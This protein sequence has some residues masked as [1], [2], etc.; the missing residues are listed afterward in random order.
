M[1]RPPWLDG[2]LL[3]LASITLCAALI[4]GTARLWVDRQARQ[5]ERSAGSPIS[6]YDPTLGWFHVAGAERRIR[7]PEFDVLL[8]FNRHGLRGPDRDYT[9]PPGVRRA[10]VLGDSF[11]EGYYVDEDQTAAAVLEGLLQACGPHEV[12][13]AGVQGYSTDQEYLLYLQEGRRYGARLVL[14]FFYGNDLRYNASPVGSGGEAKPYFDLDEHD[15]L[16]ARGTPVPPPDPATTSRAR[17]GASRPLP[18]HGSMALRLLSRR[19]VGSNPAL[20]AA[21]ARLGLVEPVSPD[22]PIELWPYGPMHPREVG[23]MWRHTRAILRAL[24]EAVAADGATLALVYVPVRFE[25]NDP[26]WELTRARYQMGRRWGTERVF[27]RLQETC[28]ELDIPLVDPRAPLR[29]AE[30][31]GA[32]AYYT[33]DVHWNARGNAIAAHAVEPL[34]R[35]VLGCAAAATDGARR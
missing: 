9:P 16:L 21:L 13:N 33:R 28:A 32:P 4:E 27:L 23:E 5:D 30:A 17:P 26:V 8:K 7:R 10:L 24:R 34:A 15:A 20:H 19:T 1:R 31:G 18:W 2:A 22:P 11:A 12:I 14:V 6:R 3:S 25:V 29:Q 35:Q